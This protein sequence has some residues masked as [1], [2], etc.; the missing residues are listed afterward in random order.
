M[1]DEDA[2][3][4]EDVLQ[5]KRGM[6]KTQCDDEGHREPRIDNDEDESFL[7]DCKEFVSHKRI[8]KQCKIDVLNS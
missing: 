3:V 6:K 1:I 5:V 7:S 2:A 4:Q 8:S